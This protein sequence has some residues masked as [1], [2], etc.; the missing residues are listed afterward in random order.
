MGRLFCSV[1]AVSA[2]VAI[3][4]STYWV[5]SARG[6]TSVVS[7]PVGDMV[8]IPMWLGGCSGSSSGS[9][10]RRRI[11]CGCGRFR[12]MVS[13]CGFVGDYEDGVARIRLTWW[14]G[15]RMCGF[16]DGIPGCRG[17]GKGRE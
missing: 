5:M 9:G 10:Q 7:S 2:M 6:N 14:N 3:K 15:P 16:G 4:S 1:I 11:L 13:A 8:L 17:P 12:G